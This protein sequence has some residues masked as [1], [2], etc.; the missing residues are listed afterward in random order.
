MRLRIFADRKQNGM[1]CMMYCCRPLPR[2]NV[3]PVWRPSHDGRFLQRMRVHASG[4]V[5]ENG[6]DYAFLKLAAH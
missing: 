3:M 5:F 2:H 6:N 1:H 4:S